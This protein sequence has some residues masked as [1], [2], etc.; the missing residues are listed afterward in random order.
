M[1][2]KITRI[3]VMCDLE[4]GGERGRVHYRKGLNPAISATE[5]KDP[6]K[7]IKKHEEKNDCDRTDGQPK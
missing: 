7:V 2:D 6:I 5:H 1:T 4:V 3:R